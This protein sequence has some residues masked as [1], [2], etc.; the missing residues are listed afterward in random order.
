MANNLLLYKR[1]YNVSQT[2][3]GIVIG[4]S[5]QTVSKKLKGKVAWSLK[6][7]VRICNYFNKIQEDQEFSI[8]QLFGDSI[9]QIS[10]ENDMT[11]WEN[12]LDRTNEE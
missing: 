7:V 6:D 5:Q 1:K 3:L 2:T 4:C 8:E 11:I 9:A 12:C 10:E